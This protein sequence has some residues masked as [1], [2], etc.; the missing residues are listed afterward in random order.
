MEILNKSER[1]GTAL[2]L[3]TVASVSGTIA[4]NSLIEEDTPVRMPDGANHVATMTGTKGSTVIIKANSA[5]QTEQVDCGREGGLV[6]N[7][8]TKRVV[9]RFV[10]CTREGDSSVPAIVSITK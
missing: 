3:I 5:E 7:E 9:G 10:L 8:A 4:V 6:K 1:L 2:G